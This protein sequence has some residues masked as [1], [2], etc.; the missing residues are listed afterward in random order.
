ML[1]TEKII[2]NTIW[3][4]FTGIILNKGHNAFPLNYDPGKF[5]HPLN[6]FYA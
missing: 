1:F 4:N 2:I 6:H 5:W 3:K